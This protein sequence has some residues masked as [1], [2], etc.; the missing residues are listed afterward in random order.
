VFVALVAC[1]PVRLAGGEEDGVD[2]E[3]ILGLAASINVM[4]TAA[5][6][7]SLRTARIMAPTVSSVGSR[8]TPG[9]DDDSFPHLFAVALLP[10]LGV[11][12]HQGAKQPT[13]HDVATAT[14]PSPTSACILIAARA[15]AGGSYLLRADEPDAA[16]EDEPEQPAEHEAAS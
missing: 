5:M 6:A 3:A 4:A 9:R 1:F 10:S 12:R 13:V 7:P 8:T 15:W 14:L 16:F 11:Q 2:D